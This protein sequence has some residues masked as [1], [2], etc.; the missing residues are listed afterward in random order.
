MTKTFLALYAKGKEGYSGQVIDVPG[1][2]SAGETLEEMRAMMREGLEGHFEVM[3]D[4]G[5]ALPEPAT[6]SIDFKPED[7]EDVE[8]F[9]VERLQ[10]EIPAQ[11]HRSEAISA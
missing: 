8:Y 5:M 11:H 6:T 1:C 2:F 9:V 4:C 10:I 3:A 7:F